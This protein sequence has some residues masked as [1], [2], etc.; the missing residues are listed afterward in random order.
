MATDAWEAARDHVA[1]LF[2]RGDASRLE[3]IEAVLDGD[4][5]ILIGADEAD[6][7]SVRQ[8]LAAVWR[9]RMVRLLDQHPDVAPDLE[10]LITAIRVRLPPEQQGWVQHNTAT[11]GGTVIAHQGTGSQHIHYDQSPSDQ[12]PLD[13]D[14]GEDSSMLLPGD[15][16]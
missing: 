5:D 16:R 6:R 3:A 9:R 8:E 2:D 10:E 1:R 4:A 11:A 12:G 7:E 15:G 13:L 14:A